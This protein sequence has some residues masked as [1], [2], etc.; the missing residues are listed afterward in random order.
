ML[1]RPTKHRLEREKKRER[2]GCVCVCV[3]VLTLSGLV[4]IA[5]F[6]FVSCPIGKMTGYIYIYYKGE[7]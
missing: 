2:E 5:S 3:C 1:I 4:S 7:K 6:D